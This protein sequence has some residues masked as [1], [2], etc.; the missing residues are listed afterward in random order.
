MAFVHGKNS[1]VEVDTLDVSD[2]ADTAELSRSLDTATVTGF[3]DCANEYIPGMQDATF[4]LSGSWDGDALAIDEKLD[5]IYNGFV[6][7]P[8]KFGPNGSGATTGDVVYDGS[9]ILTDAP[10][11]SSVGDKVSWSATFQ[12]TGEVTRTV[13]P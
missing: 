2:F 9:A 11:P 13:T 8:F 4:T 5:A 7:V 6:A 3:G 12:V 1:Y 10:V